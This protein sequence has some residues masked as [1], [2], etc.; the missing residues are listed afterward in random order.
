MTLVEVKA[1]REREGEIKAGQS[2]AKARRARKNKKTRAAGGGKKAD[3]RRFKFTEIYCTVVFQIRACFRVI[4]SRLY[5]HS[6]LLTR[7]TAFFLLLKQ[8][9]TN[10]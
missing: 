7:I 3:A 6:R 5:I 1:E 2:A 10:V 4:F 8:V 9:N